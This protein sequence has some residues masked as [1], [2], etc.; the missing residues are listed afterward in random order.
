[1][2]LQS[3][4]GALKIAILVI[5]ATFVIDLTNRFLAYWHITTTFTIQVFTRSKESQ[6]NL[7]NLF[8]LVGGQNWI[9][10]LV[11]LHKI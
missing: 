9:R 4:N 3:I 10:T 8:G 11:V 7:V 5:K 2:E 1:M 6:R